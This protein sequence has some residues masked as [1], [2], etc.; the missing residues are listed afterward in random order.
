[1]SIKLVI[2]G[3]FLPLPLDLFCVE[4]EFQKDTSRNK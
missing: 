1:L 3:I 2:E 4:C